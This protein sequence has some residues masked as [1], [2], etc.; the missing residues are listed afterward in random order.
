MRLVGIAPLLAYIGQ[1]AVL[2]M[3]TQSPLCHPITHPRAIIVSVLEVSRGG[4]AYAPKNM[5]W[6]RGAR[7]WWWSTRV[8]V[9]RCGVTQQYTLQ[10]SR[11]TADKDYKTAAITTRLQR[12]PVSGDSC[13]QQ[14]QPVITPPHTHTPGIQANHFA[15]LPSVLG[16]GGCDSNFKMH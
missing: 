11:I 15:A 3:H 6:G 16:D 2:F 10:K 1:G 7:G 4:G 12:H 5:R 14:R 9:P 8:V 13:Q